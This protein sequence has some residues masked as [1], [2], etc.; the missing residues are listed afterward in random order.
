MVFTAVKYCSI[1]YRRVIVKFRPQGQSS[2]KIVVL[3]GEVARSTN[4]FKFESL[5]LHVSFVQNSPS[6][7]DSIKQADCLKR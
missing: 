7:A 4:I 6:V 5:V 3:S 1:L 2:V